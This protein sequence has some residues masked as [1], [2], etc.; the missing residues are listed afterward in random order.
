MKTIYVTGATNA[1]G[2]SFPKAVSVCLLLSYLSSDNV[3]DK[4]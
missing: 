2:V 3:E 1:R 4:G